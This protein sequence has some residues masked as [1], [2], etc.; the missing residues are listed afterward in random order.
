MIDADRGIYRNR[1]WGTFTYDLE[2]SE[3]GVLNWEDVLP[4]NTRHPLQSGLRKQI[5]TA[6]IMDETGM[7]ECIEA[8]GTCAEDT[9]A[10]LVEYC[11][12]TDRMDMCNA[13]DWYVRNYV[14]IL[15][16]NVDLR[17]LCISN[18]LMVM[19]DGQF[20]MDFFKGISGK[21]G[22]CPRPAGRDQQ[23]GRSQ[24]HQH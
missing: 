14:S 9:I 19:D 18:A 12:F 8:M 11:I 1:V 5:S 7:T 23:Q 3:Y 22:R 16:P 15:Y 17:S 24:R 10:V 21:N 4:L 6:W 13:L 20:H 2:T